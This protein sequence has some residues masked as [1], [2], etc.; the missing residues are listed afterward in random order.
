MRSAREP[1]DPAQCYEV[2]DPAN[3]ISLPVA[4]AIH[5]VSERTI[6]NWIY[7]GL[8]TLYKVGPRKSRVDRTEVMQLVTI[9]CTS[10]GIDHSGGVQ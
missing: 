6:R 7:S 3:L 10:R 9:A 4:A 5:D 1:E 8:L 2:V